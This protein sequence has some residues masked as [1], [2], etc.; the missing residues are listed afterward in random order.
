M[1]SCVCLDVVISAPYG[2][3]GGVIYV[4]HGSVSGIK[5]SPSQVMTKPIGMYYVYTACT[6]GLIS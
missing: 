6:S 4:Y 2:E 3:T 5:E 1:H